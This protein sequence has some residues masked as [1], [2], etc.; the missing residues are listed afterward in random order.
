MAPR[1][2]PHDQFHSGVDGA[3]FEAALLGGYCR[4]CGCTDDRACMTEEGPCAWV[5]PGLCSACALISP[6]L[7]AELGRERVLIYSEGAANAF[8]R[9]W[10]EGR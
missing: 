8:L 10:R 3:A 4:H 2:I 5:E 9:E 6:E 7:F 1:L